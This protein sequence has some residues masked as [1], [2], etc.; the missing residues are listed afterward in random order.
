MPAFLPSSKRVEF[1]D[2]ELE[3]NSDNNFYLA[4]NKIKSDA[5]F[6]PQFVHALIKEMSRYLREYIFY[7]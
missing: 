1:K 5:R 4:V 2:F 6:K 3:F 7:I